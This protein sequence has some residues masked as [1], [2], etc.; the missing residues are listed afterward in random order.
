[1]Y[2]RITPFVGHIT[3]KIFN[4]DLIMRL[5]VL[6]IQTF[7]FSLDSHKRLSRFVDW[8]GNKD[9][10]LLRNGHMSWLTVVHVSYHLTQ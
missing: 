6:R 10:A 2:R 3:K 5:C 4:S 9:V 7:I 1:M 8:T